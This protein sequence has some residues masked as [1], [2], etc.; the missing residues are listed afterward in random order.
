MT[1][2]DSAAELDRLDPQDFG[3]CFD[4]EATEEIVAA[5]LERVVSSLF[6]EQGMSEIYVVGMGG[7]HKSLYEEVDAI[8]GAEVLF[9]GSL[10]PR[11]FVFLR[12]IIASYRGLV[13]VSNRDAARKV[14]EMLVTRSM[15]GIY[16][17]P[18]CRSREFESAVKSEKRPTDLG[19]GLGIDPRHFYFIVDED[20]AESSTGCYE[21]VSY[22]R[23]V[24][25]ELRF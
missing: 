8:E 15:A 4:N 19:F 11:V 21:I 12:P 6:D 13:R 10:L 9:Q 5:R 14:F 2:N 18:N 25:A 24:P 22:G 7:Q 3:T 20:N 23:D 1:S 17:C 16:L